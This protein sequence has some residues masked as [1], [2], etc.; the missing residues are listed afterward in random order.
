[1]AL[2]FSPK[3]G[4]NRNC[5]QYNVAG[6]SW[7]IATTSV[8][9]HA[10]RTP[11]LYNEYIYILDNTNPEKYNFL[12]NT[13]SAGIAPPIFPG[14]QPCVARYMDS[15]IVL[16]GT[17]A[18]TANQQYNF[19][20]KLW[21]NLTPLP[22]GHQHFGCALLPST[23]KRSTIPSPV[24]DKILLVNNVVNDN[25]ATIYDIT[26]KI[27]LPVPNMVQG[28]R[29]NNVIVLGQRVFV[30]TGYWGGANTVVEEYHQHNNSWTV[31][32]FK[33]L[34]GRWHSS[35]VAVPAV[36]FKNLPGSCYGVI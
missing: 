9:T 24:Q 29:H 4:D 27:F 31:V 10:W 2:Y 3:V 18:N 7:S 15:I 5:W 19:T 17:S 8:F 21:K 13:W 28:H 1:M 30:M 35:T 22:F 14:N 20:T 12:D 36:W 32:P 11:I 23:T 25:S 33:I 26:K 34:F 16:G 6:N